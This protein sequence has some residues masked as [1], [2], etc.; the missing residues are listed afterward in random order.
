MGNTFLPDR[1]KATAEPSR[2]Q[3]TSSKTGSSGFFPGKASCPKSSTRAAAAAATQSPPPTW[4]PRASESRSS[5]QK[6]LDFAVSHDHVIACSY[7]SQGCEGGF[8]LEVARFSAENQLVSEAT[9]ASLLD[10]ED[11]A[12]RCRAA[13]SKSTARCGSNPGKVGVGATEYGMV[14]G[15]YPPTSNKIP[16]PDPALA[17]AADGGRSL[18]D[19]AQNEERIMDEIFRNGPVAFNFFAA[20]DL[21]LYR[22]GVYSPTSPQSS[23]D[24]KLA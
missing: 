17:T 9:W 4:P 1:Q 24:V 10:S 20:P 6:E 16:N 5:H 21:Y 23:L 19:L 8:S 3:K 2:L 15:S 12:S 13:N 18:C 11:D 22:S 14:L 7:Y